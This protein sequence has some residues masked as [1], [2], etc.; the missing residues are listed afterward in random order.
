[1]SLLNHEFL[2]EL[3]AL[4]IPI[5]LYFFFKRQIK[6]VYFSSIR[7]LKE[8]EA[9]SLIKSSW[10]EIIILILRILTILFLVLGFINPII[11]KNYWFTDNLKSVHF[12][13]LDRSN[14]L[15]IT[16]NN[17]SLLQ[18][19]NEIILEFF[20][21][22]KPSEKVF[23]VNPKNSEIVLITK[24]SSFNVLEQF[25]PIKIDSIPV[26]NILKSITSFCEKEDYTSHSTYF[27]SS[28]KM[29]ADNLYSIGLDERFRNDRIASVKIKNNILNKD[30]S[31]SLAIDIQL[32]SI[33]SERLLDIIID[34]KTIYSELLEPELSEINIGRFSEGKHSGKV[35]LSSDDHFLDDNHFYFNFTILSE[36]KI[37]VFYKDDDSYLYAFFKNYPDSISKVTLSKNTDIFK[38]NLSDFNQIFYE[39]E[40]VSSSFHTN[41]L[42][43]LKNKLNSFIYIP[44]EYLKTEYWNQSEFKEF[45]KL[46][47]HPMVRGFTRSLKIKNSA[48]LSLLDNEKNINP[49]NLNDSFFVR[50]NKQ[51]ILGVKNNQQLIRHLESNFYF[52]TSEFN[53]SKSNFV[54]HEV[55]SPTLFFL[56]NQQNRSA[57]YSDNTLKLFGNEKLNQNIIATSSVGNINFYQIKKQP[58]LGIFTT[59]SDIVSSNYTI[60]KNEKIHLFSV[61]EPTINTQNIYFGNTKTILLPHSETGSLW[62][63]CLLLALLCYLL[64]LWLGRNIKPK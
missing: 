17:K 34:G 52:F 30:I 51:I 31:L 62:R 48:V 23:V 21:Q 45:F 19:R 61:N 42:S 15:K 47:Q 7:F 12:L 58:F 50:S 28:K 35:L 11:S 60:N 32:D 53:T 43:Y 4:L 5:I 64:E 22:I 24:K 26:K 27:L 20:D 25:F 14:E 29:L 54:I 40:S 10:L 3:F 46:E 41:I 2:P 49:L 44:S 13:V 1:L 36:Q 63:I 37:L 38:H 55:F 39:G 33:V 57:I 59:N 9:N 56:M 18:K 16:Q 8:I 6:R